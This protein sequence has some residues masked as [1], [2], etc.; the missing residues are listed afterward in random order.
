MA[1][2]TQGSVEMMVKNNGATVSS[3][4]IRDKEFVMI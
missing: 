3:D 2:D 4:E 1:V